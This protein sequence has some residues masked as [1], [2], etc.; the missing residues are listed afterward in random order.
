L[1]LKRSSRSSEI[2]PIEQRLQATKKESKCFPI[3]CQAGRSISTDYPLR[4]CIV[5]CREVPSL[6]R[7]G[8]VR[9]SVTVQMIAAE[10]FG[11][12]AATSSDRCA[13]RL[14][15][16]SH[17]GWGVDFEVSVHVRRR[18]DYECLVK[19]GI[20]N[21]QSYTSSRGLQ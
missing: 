19:L 16:G 10:A 1:R 20:S 12:K 13:L 9:L 7:L 15:P 2:R 4:A 3:L 8:T 21:Y 6:I 14:G 11:A 5:S 18:R 17:K